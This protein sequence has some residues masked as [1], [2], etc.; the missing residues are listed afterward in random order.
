MY[1]VFTRPYP[2]HWAQWQVSLGKHV[3]RA[4]SREKLAPHE[5]NGMLGFEDPLQEGSLPGRLGTEV[6]QETYHEPLTAIVRSYLKT[7]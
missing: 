2:G 6:V 7:L 5:M 1:L 3:R 4:L